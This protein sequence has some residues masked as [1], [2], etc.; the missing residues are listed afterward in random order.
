MCVNNWFS[1]YIIIKYVKVND[2]N[3]INKEVRWCWSDV[4]DL[5]I[6]L[7]LKMCK[8]FVIFYVLVIV[9]KYLNEENFVM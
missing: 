4:G 2:I 5:V 1:I 6:Y 3:K 7:C 9:Y 8:F